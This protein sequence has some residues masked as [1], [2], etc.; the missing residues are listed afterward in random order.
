MKGE[1]CLSSYY[2][3]IFVNQSFFQ[4]T[5][6]INVIMTWLDLTKS[7]FSFNSNVLKTFCRKSGKDLE[8]FDNKLEKVKFILKEKIVLI[9]L[10]SVEEY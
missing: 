10:D 1:Y 9:I 8:T 6:S 7:R 4:A 2:L 3:F 5:K